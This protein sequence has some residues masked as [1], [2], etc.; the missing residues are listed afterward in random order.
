MRWKQWWWRWNIGKF[1]PG[2]SS[3]ML[4][5]EQKEQHKQVCQELLSQYETESDCYLDY[6][7]SGDELWCHY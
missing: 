4:T 6:I 2:E 1:V 7:I 3:Q 5:K